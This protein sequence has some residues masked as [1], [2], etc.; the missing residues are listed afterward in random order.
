MRKKKKTNKKRNLFIA[1]TMIK[2]KSKYHKASLR[3]MPIKGSFQTDER[4]FKI[5]EPPLDRSLSD[6]DKL[7]KDEQ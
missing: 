2:N 6:I 3:T 4:D 1:S 5:A 7:K